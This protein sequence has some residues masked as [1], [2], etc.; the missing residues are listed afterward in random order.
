MRVKRGGGV[1]GSDAGVANEAAPF[2]AFHR[3]MPEDCAEVLFRKREEPGQSWRNQAITRL[4]FRRRRN[5][6]G[7]IPGTDVLADVTAEDLPAHGGPQV[8][9]DLAAQLDR[10]VGDTA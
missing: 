2:C 7:S 8:L 3:A 5:R 9:G 6:R 10:E 1:A 4:K